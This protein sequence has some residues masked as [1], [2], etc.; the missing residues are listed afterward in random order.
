MIPQFESGCRLQM[1]K[2]KFKNACDTVTDT[3]RELKGIGTLGEK[4]LHC[5]IKHYIEPDISWHEVKIGSYYADIVTEDGIFEI[6]TRSFNSLRKKLAFFLEFSPVTIVYPLPKT[7][8]LLWI[9]KDT[10]EVTKKRKSPK[11]GRIYDAFYE[12]YKIKPQIIDENFRFHII[13]IDVE[14]YRYLDGWSDDKKRGSS[15]CERIPIDIASEERFEKAADYKKFVPDELPNQFTT[16][17]YKSIAKVNLRTAQTAMNILHHL[18]VVKRVGK[19]KKLHL[20][21]RCL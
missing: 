8:W 1:D 4:M 15:R 7:K 13:F 9:D 12:L 2:Q 21:E 14:E 10:G 11:Q 18:G 3:V 5:V 16:K 20:Y 17:D 6:Q 19:E